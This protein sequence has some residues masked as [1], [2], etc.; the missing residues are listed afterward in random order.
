MH[1]FKRFGKLTEGVEMLRDTAK[2]IL[3]PARASRRRTLL[4][5]LDDAV[6]NHKSYFDQPLAS[7]TSD[8]DQTVASFLRIRPLLKALCRDS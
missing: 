8:T 4:T 2:R 5:L 6:Q 3:A 7:L 1:Q